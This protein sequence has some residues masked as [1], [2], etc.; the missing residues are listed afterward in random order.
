MALV[1]GWRHFFTFRP[2]SH[3]PIRSLPHW[4]LATLLLAA[5]R[6]PVSDTNTRRVASSAS[7]APAS[8][9]IVVSASSVAASA[10]TASAPSDSKGSAACPQYNQGMA[11]GRALT[12]AGRYQE[13]IQAFDRAVR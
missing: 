2:Q 13:A 4:V 11:K 3:M 10:P 12:K 8:V 5:C 7:S 6:H 1:L 9:G